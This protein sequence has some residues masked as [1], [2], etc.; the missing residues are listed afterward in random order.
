M[1]VHLIDGTFELFRAYYG[2]PSR[3]SPEGK[4]VGAT[5]SFLHSLYRLTQQKE[6]T[7][8]ACAFDTVI[9]SFRN[10]LFDGYKTGEGIE[11]ELLSQFP[12]VEKASRALGVVTWSMKKFEAD[13]A[14]ATA[15]HRYGDHP[16]VK[17]VVICS[18]DKDLAQCVRGK[19]VIC[20][21]RIRDTYLDEAGVKKKFGV[22][23]K[24]I[25]DWLALVGDSA[26]GIPG[27]PRWGAKSASAVLGKYAHIE[28]IPSSELSWKVKVRGASSLSQSL[29]GLRKEAELYRKLATL[30]VDVP[31]KETLKDLEWKSYSS[32][33]LRQLCQSLGD[34]RFLEQ[35]K[36]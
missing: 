30:R 28:E 10:K 24:S 8:I 19:K 33:S 15:V 14:I 17:Q 25:P 16:S 12:L 6:V 22:S 21:D 9:E 3:L 29:E 2:A 1:K 34:S 26:D 35:L 23:P 18:P 36:L 7:H 11:P 5:R 31:L 13:D 4:E 20:W 27:V 32:R